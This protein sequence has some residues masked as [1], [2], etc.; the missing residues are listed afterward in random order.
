MDLRGIPFNPT[1]PAS[2]LMMRLSD[3][4]AGFTVGNIYEVVALVVDSD[5]ALPQPKPYAVT[6]NDNGRFAVVDTAKLTRT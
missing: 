2:S 4:Q 6:F 5:A 3:P 1:G